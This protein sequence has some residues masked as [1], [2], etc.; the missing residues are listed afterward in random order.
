MSY[1]QNRIIH[2][3]DS[4][5]MELADCLDPFIDPKYRSAYDDLPK[6]EILAT[7]QRLGHWCARKAE[8]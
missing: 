8:G 5:L 3:A 7:G 1:A 4:H 2:D 6:A